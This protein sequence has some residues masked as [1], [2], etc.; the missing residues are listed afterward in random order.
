[1]LFEEFVRR[2]QSRAR[3][4]S[5]VGAIEATRAT[6]QTLTERIGIDEAKYLAAQLPREIREYLLD[7]ADGQEAAQQF[8]VEDFFQRVA[9]IEDVEISDS[10]I[11]ARVVMEVLSE[12]VSDAAMNALRNKLP[13]QFQLLFE[14]VDTTALRHRK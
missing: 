3:L 4:G 10:I 7:L 13:E 9:Q 8:S 6:L 5:S 12:A 11:H 14:S 2:V 1:M